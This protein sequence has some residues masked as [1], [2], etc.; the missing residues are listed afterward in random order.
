MKVTEKTGNVVN[1]VSVKDDDSIIVTTK[2]GQVVRTGLG[3]VRVMGRAAQGVRIV[4]LN[5]GD[6][7]SDVIKVVHEEEIIPEEN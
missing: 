4:N 7:I 5:D 2:N 1:T 3:S 6:K